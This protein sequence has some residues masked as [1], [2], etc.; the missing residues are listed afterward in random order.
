MKESY[1]YILSNK[2]RSV[3]YTGV[4]ADFSTRMR[5][6]LEGNGSIFCKK[7][8]VNELIY[9]ELFMN[10]TDAIQREKEIKG[11]RREKKLDLIKRRNPELKNLLKRGDKF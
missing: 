11:W 7:Y 4:T 5:S 8:N 10:I 3:F 9:Y 2:N 6:H 1:I